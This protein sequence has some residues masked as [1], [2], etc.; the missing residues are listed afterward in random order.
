MFTEFG[1]GKKTGRFASDAGNDFVGYLGNAAVRIILKNLGEMAE[2][3]GKS[4]RPAIFWQVFSIS[5]GFGFCQRFEQSAVELLF[6][7]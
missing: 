6:F 7:G 1:F 2:S 5:G 3:P 4:V